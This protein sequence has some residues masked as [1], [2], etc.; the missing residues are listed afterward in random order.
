[1]TALLFQIKGKF[2][3]K[4]EAAI[5]SEPNTPYDSLVHVMDAVRSGKSAQGGTALA[6][7]D[8]FPNISVGDAP[9]RKQ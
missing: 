3:D 2:P 4:R 6:R 5:L 7:V 9:T 1:L 8:L